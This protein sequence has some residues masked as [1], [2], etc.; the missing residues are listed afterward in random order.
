MHQFLD[1]RVVLTNSQSLVGGT[2][3]DQC[4]KG[5]PADRPNAVDF[6]VNVRPRVAKAGED[7]FIAL[8]M[9]HRV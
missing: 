8:L 1:R 4:A 5:V 6:L 7:E 3:G 9:I 2:C